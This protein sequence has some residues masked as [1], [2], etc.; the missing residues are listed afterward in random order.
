MNEGAD[1]VFVWGLD[2]EV[3][4]LSLSNGHWHVG[5]IHPDNTSPKRTNDPA[6]HPLSLEEVSKLLGSDL[7]F[8]ET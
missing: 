3:S 1:T 8:Y 5:I 6:W 4:V 7:H 2:H